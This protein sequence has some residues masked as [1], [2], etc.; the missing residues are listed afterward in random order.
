MKRFILTLIAMA[1][2]TSLS[3]AQ[4]GYWTDAGLTPRTGTIDVNTN[5]N[6][7]NNNNLE[8]GDISIA[9]NNDIVLA[10]EDDQG[11]GGPLTD[12][13]A[14]W[15]LFDNNGN[16]LITP[17]TITNIASA[18]CISTQEELTNTT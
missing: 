4:V 7:G 18:N 3:L 2:A 5:G 13:E 10:W 16:L 1:A 6:F 14:V 11:A 8:T 17:T 15:T 9:A 12:Y